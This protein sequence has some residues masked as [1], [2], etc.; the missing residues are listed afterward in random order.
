M[1][2]EFDEIVASIK[3]ELPPSPDARLNVILTDGSILEFHDVSGRA[4][5]WT[6]LRR[7]YAQL[8]DPKDNWCVLFTHG[9]S[10]IVARKETA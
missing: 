9:I 4:L 1:D 8:A 7:G 3:D 10:A 5:A 6:L 2:D